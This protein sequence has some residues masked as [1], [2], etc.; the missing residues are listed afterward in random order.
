M[1]Q[2]FLVNWIN[3]DSAIESLAL[4]GLSFVPNLAGLIILTYFNWH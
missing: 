3:T 1:N 2:D 4:W